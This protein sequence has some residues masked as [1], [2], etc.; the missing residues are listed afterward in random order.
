MKLVLEWVY[1]GTN[2]MPLTFTN[3]QLVIIEESH[4]TFTSEAANH[5]DTQGALLTVGLHVIEAVLIETIVV[6]D[7]C[8]EIFFMRRGVFGAVQIAETLPDRF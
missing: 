2:V 8:L 5:V 3:Q 4:W 6:F 1:R 7:E